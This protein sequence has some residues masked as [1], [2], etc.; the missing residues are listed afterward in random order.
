MGMGC[1][2]IPFFFHIV[3][4]F[5]VPILSD[6]NKRKIAKPYQ[7]KLCDLFSCGDGGRPS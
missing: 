7:I 6:F 3:T 5:I 1:V 2:S 4:C